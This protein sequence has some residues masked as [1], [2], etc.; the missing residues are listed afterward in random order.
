MKPVFPPA[1]MTPLGSRHITGALMA[2]V[3]AVSIPGGTS[4]AAGFTV[5]R[6]MQEA[7]ADPDPKKANTACSAILD[8]GDI[9]VYAR[10]VALDARATS[11]LELGDASRARAD[12]EALVRLGREPEDVARANALLA[13]ALALGGQYELALSAVNEALKLDPS[14]GDD[15]AL[16]GDILDRLNRDGE[17]ER[18]LSAVVALR[19]NQANPYLNR[20]RF[21]FYRLNYQRAEDDFE[22]AVANAPTSAVTP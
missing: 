16:R 12:A 6:D 5:T 21:Y 14:D 11:L 9:P 17:A 1:W 18:D 8:L 10:R 7:C 2:L 22:H 3:F 4:R 15:L 13:Q 20:G 19:R